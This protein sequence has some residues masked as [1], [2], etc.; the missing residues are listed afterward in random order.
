[1]FK[2]KDHKN[3]IIKKAVV[4]LLPKLAAYSVEQFQEHLKASVEHL[5]DYIDKKVNKLAK[6]AGFMALGE[7][8]VIVD[9]NNYR[10]FIDRILEKLEF[11]ITKAKKPF[12]L[13]TFDCIKMLTKHFGPELCKKI[14][15][16]KIIDNMF[17]AGLSSN[18]IE[19]LKELSN[20]EN[21]CLK[22]S[23]QI[24]LLNSLSL[25]LTNKPFNF[26]S[27]ISRANS[28][29]R[30]NSANMFAESIVKD[31]RSMDGD[32]ERKEGE[33]SSGL[34][35]DGE[36]QFAHVNQSNQESEEGIEFYR[37]TDPDYFNFEVRKSSSNLR[38]SLI[39][40]Y[41]PNPTNKEVNPINKETL[42]NL[43]HK[44]IQ[45]F[46]YYFSQPSTSN[47][48]MAISRLA[49]R[50]IGTFD[51]SDFSDSLVQFVQETVLTF[52]DNENPAIRKEAIKTGCS[53]YIHPHKTTTSIELLINDILERFLTVS[54]TDADYKIRC[55]MLKYLNPRFDPFL[56]KKRNLKLLFQCVNDNVYEVKQHSIE[57]LGRL[58]DHNPSIVLPYIRNILIELLSKLEYSAD[59]KEKEE[60]AK[61]INLL[62][63]HT[64][65][66]LES[67]TQPILKALIP[68]LKQ[69]NLN[70]K[71]RSSL[72]SAILEAIG[73]LST[74]NFQNFNFSQGGRRNNAS[75]FTRNNSFN[76]RKLKRSK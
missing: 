75:K 72:T 65:G 57:I 33:E 25:I 19:T 60:S 16:E 30:E 21:K 66:M 58:V 32:K 10:V 14:N 18:L 63:Y 47:D 4:Q 39:E 52:L 74:V 34:I 11:E 23:I 50:T 76:S 29:L 69:L 27:T 46:N 37:R 26:S 5:F 6:G 44:I 68:R 38:D 67:Y 7:L 20:I 13:E 31:K 61:L 17:Y 3:L 48:K 42:K 1:M 70:S 56:S 36:K 59:Y 62:I 43:S 8:S 49:L 73:Q 24:R 40:E 22:H 71:S 45:A 55:N 15:I 2:H 28:A 64:G 12:S 9:K 41:L 53:L 51:F 35:L 54:I